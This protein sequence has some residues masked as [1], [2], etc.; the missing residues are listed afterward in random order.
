M[1]IRPIHVM[2]F[3]FT[4]AMV[5]IALGYFFWLLAGFAR[6]STTIGTNITTTGLFTSSSTG[7]NS[8]SGS[9]DVSKGFTANNIRTATYAGD[10]AVTLRSGGSSAL[11]IDT[12]GAASLT[13]GG[14]NANALTLARTGIVSIFNDDIRVSGNDIQDSDSMS[15]ITF[16]TTGST[17]L[18]TAT[19]AFA[20]TTYLKS[21]DELIAASAAQ[22]GG[23]AT[24]SYSRFGTN[25]TGHS[26]S[27]ASDL[28]ISGLLE[29]DGNAFF[30]SNA[31]LAGNFELT[32][33]SAKLGANAG[34]TIDT[35]LEIGGTASISGVLTLADGEIRPR[36]NGV[37]AF[38]FQNAT[39]GTDILTL[40]ATNARVGI[41]AGGT[42]D[43]L[44][45]VGGT[46]SISTVS[47]GSI[48]TASNCASSALP[49]VCGSASAGGVVVA[50]T[51]TT[52]TVNTTA[53]TANSQILVTVDSSLGSRLSVTCNSTTPV[54][55]VTSRT[56]GTSFVITVTVA[57]LTNP[58][59]FDYLI[60]N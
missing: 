27:A 58:A 53:V 25:T 4:A 52:V 46:A 1:K 37:T 41:N 51:A 2:N 3:G 9:L 31:S 38:R 42:I 13:I 11:T 30:D 19:G 35:M 56:A 21:G 33:S 32:F 28:L 48:K 16:T 34:G 23:T 55:S 60:I 18:T 54:Y 39:G 29:V 20:T 5:F 40:D 10:G 15:R 6:A 43:T 14:T 45:E 7:S 49:A 26:L 8:F 17:G 57:P 47:A 36:T 44:F 22:F 24:L 12:G 50:A 59:C